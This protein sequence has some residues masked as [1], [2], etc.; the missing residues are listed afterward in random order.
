MISVANRRG[1][2]VKQYLACHWFLSVV[3]NPEF[4]ASKKSRQTLPSASFGLVPPL[5]FKGIGG[6]VLR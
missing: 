6:F 5:R 4:V 2:A 3:I 1:Y